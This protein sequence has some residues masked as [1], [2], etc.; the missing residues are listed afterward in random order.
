MA[1]QPVEFSGTFGD[2]VSVTT[3]R[4]FKGS[5]MVV[6]RPGDF[7]KALIKIIKF[8]F[9]FAVSLIFL[10]GF[11]K[12][13]CEVD[14]DNIVGYL[15]FDFFKKTPVTE[16]TVPTSQP[17]EPLSKKLRELG[18]DSHIVVVRE[19]KSSAEAEELEYVLR[20]KR[21]FASDLSYKSK[22]YVYIGPLY[23]R[24]YMYSVLRKVHDLGYENAYSL[25]PN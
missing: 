15:R 19:C 12:I 1:G 8:I 11:F 20:Q 21:V 7:C 24:N 3:Q 5:G 13:I 25:R 23:S 17:E 4:T 14:N 9:M 10:F 18:I 16:V 6:S 22:H 2:T